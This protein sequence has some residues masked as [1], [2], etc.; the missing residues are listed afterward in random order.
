[1]DSIDYDEFVL[2][3]NVLREYNEMKEEI[4][5]SKDDVEYTIQLS[6]VRKILRAKVQVSEE[7]KEI[8]YHLC[9]VA[10]YVPR[11]NQ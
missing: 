1:M 11:K 9:R 8:D 5:S 10:L 7:L 6:V 2:V 3:N 4:K